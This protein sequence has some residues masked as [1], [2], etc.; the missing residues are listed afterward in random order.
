MDTKASQVPF[1]EGGPIETGNRVSVNVGI[2]WM[3]WRELRRRYTFNP[4]GPQVGEAFRSKWM[5]MVARTTHDASDRTLSVD[6]LSRVEI[7]QTNYGEMEG[8]KPAVDEEQDDGEQEYWPTELS[9]EADNGFHKPAVQP[10]VARLPAVGKRQRDDL[11]NLDPDPSGL[12]GVDE[13]EPSADADADAPASAPRLRLRLRLRLRRGC[14]N[15]CCNF[16]GISHG[17]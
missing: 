16:I 12:K 6:T 7:R 8:S 10:P 3:G 1:F 11:D 9:K 5:R 17:S 2:C 4:N 15:A 14:N 13:R